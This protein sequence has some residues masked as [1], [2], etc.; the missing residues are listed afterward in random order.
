MHVDESVSL[1]VFHSLAVTESNSI[2]ESV[3]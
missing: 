1:C 2:I 3:T